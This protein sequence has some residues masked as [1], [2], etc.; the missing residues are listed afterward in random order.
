MDGYLEPLAGPKSE[1]GAWN[2]SPRSHASPSLKLLSAFS[3]PLY[4]RSRPREDPLQDRWK[5][6]A[7]QTVAF[8]DP[9]PVVLHL[10]ACQMATGP[11]VTSFITEPRRP[12]WDCQSTRILLGP[13]LW[14]GLKPFLES[15]WVP[16]GVR[17]N[18]PVS[19]SSL[20]GSNPRVSLNEIPLHGPCYPA[21]VP[22]LPSP[23][24]AL[25]WAS[26]EKS[27]KTV[28]IPRPQR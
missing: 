24:P 22:A 14:P 7:G 3:P 9:A 23:A 26:Q 25:L 4:Q 12:I 19:P 13:F 18:H 15:P 28:N 27:P 2:F 21:P 10:G 16:R 8:P 20:L 6:V 5:E 1:R 11:A 17:A